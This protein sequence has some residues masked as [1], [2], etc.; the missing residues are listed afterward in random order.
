[1]ESASP[2]EVGT[3]VDVLS[4]RGTPVVRFRKEV[5]T[6]LSRGE[7]LL[8]KDASS[9]FRSVRTNVAG[10]VESDAFSG[11]TKVWDGVLNTLCDSDN[12]AI[13]M[14]ENLVERGSTLLMMLL[15]RY[16][17]GVEAVARS[18]YL[19]EGILRRILNTGRDWNY[20]Y[21]KTSRKGKV[22][23][24]QSKRFFQRLHELR[25]LFVMV[26]EE[27]QREN[28]FVPKVVVLI[29][30][31]LPVCS[32]VGMDLYDKP[33]RLGKSGGFGGLSAVGWRK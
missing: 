31:M 17:Q 16:T 26:V 24:A 10:F 19:Y 28:I 1:V 20:I 18:S 11:W 7:A 4:A 9:F 32:K 6:K 2:V 21:E 14:R 25:C 15:T 3:P 12:V 33:G 23:I 5:W 27:W 29:Q 13:M 30:G 8:G 22:S